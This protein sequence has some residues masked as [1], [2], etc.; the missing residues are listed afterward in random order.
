VSANSAHP[1][2]FEGC[3]ECAFERALRG[4]SAAEGMPRAGDAALIDR[5]FEGGSSPLRAPGPARRGVWLSVPAAACLLL[6]VSVAAGAAMVAV[7]RF[8]H[9]LGSSPSTAATRSTHPYAAVAPTPAVGAA[10]PPPIE[11]LKPATVP[12]RR[13]AIGASAPAAYAATLFAEANRLRHQGAYESAAVAYQRLIEGSPGSR[14]G[15]AALVVLAQLELDR[16]GAPSAALPLFE[17]YLKAQPHGPLAEEA[18]V[19]RAVA[20]ERLDRPAQER[21]AWLELL[22][23]H[24]RSVHDDQAKN[25]LLRLR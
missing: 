13:L 2:D 9:H 8:W 15:L 19:G 22:Q 7:P 20:L 14:E 5:L 6:L 10:S 17:R 3:E 4:D 12:R 11:P 23:E 24:P 25:R 21:A 18:R 1:C 16:R